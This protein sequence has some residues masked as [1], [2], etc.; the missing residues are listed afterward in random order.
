MRPV[1]RKSKFSHTDQVNKRYTVLGEWH[2]AG[3]VVVR[4]LRDPGAIPTPDFP[5]FYL[6]TLRAEHRQHPDNSK[7]HLGMRPVSTAHLARPPGKPGMQPLPA[8]MFVQAAGAFPNTNGVPLLTFMEVA[9]HPIR[10]DGKYVQKAYA[11]WSDI[12]SAEAEL[13]AEGDLWQAGDP[14]DAH[15][16]LHGLFPSSEEAIEYAVTGLTSWDAAR[17]MGAFIDDGSVAY[18]SK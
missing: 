17:R 6:V 16:T 13:K 14:D 12:A 4:H 15:S 3:N 10:I 18:S 9:I 11:Q 1:L 7:P 2:R 5:D 8:P